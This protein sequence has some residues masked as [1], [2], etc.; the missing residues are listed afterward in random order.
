M[1]KTGNMITVREVKTRKDRKVF[2]DFPLDLYAGNPCFVP[3][4]RMDE[5]KIFHQDYVY[6]DCCDAVC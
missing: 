1:P 4:L 6:N 2:L 3:P 5:R